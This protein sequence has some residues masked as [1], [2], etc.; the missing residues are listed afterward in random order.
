MTTQCPKCKAENPDE[1]KFYHEHGLQLDSD[2][3][4]AAP[5]TALEA[6][7]EELTIGSIFAERNQIIEEL[8]KGG[9]GTVYR[10]E[11]SKIGQEIA[12]ELI[13]L[14]IASYKITI[15]RF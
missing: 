15:E 1:S 14:K 7:R 5:T 2:D 12:Q 13:K 10:V 4:I 9:M 11:E 3:Q 6:P 8:G